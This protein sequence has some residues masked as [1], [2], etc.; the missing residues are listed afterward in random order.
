MVFNEAKAKCYLCM[1]N[2]IPVLFI[3][4]LDVRFYHFFSVLFYSLFAI[5]FF[6]FSVL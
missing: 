6:W 1:L 4:S 3:S 5:L 2:V